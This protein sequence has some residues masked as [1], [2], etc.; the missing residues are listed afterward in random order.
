MT[1]DYTT[2]EWSHEDTPTAHECYTAFRWGGQVMGTVHNIADHR[3]A[4]RLAYHVR[5]F[6]VG[7]YRHSNSL[8]DFDTLAEAQAV[9]KEYEAKYRPVN[10]EYRTEIY[11]FE[12]GVFPYAEKGK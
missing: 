4:P 9:A 12:V 8:G 3:K 6:G 5:E 7:V 1:Y 2:D 10:S 11:S